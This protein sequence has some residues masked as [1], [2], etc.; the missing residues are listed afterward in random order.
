M[1]INDRDLKNLMDEVAVLKKSFSGYK[2]ISLGE[3]DVLESVNGKL[4]EFDALC[5]SNAFFDGGFTARENLDAVAFYLNGV[6]I[7]I[8]SAVSGENYFSFGGEVKNGK[9][10]LFIKTTRLP[11]IGNERISVLGYVEKKDY[12]SRISALWFDPN[13]FV[14]MKNGAKKNFTIDIVSNGVK[15]RVA[16]SLDSVCAAA[17]LDGESF[18]LVHGDGT[19]MKAVKFS[20]ETGLVVGEPINFE[21]DANLFSG[22]S[23]DDGALF[24]AQEHGKIK[25][26]LFDDSLNLTVTDTGLEGKEVFDCGENVI[27]VVCFD[28]R[29]K[30]IV[31]D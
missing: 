6:Q 15:R 22:G 19:R 14:V 4:F 29:V 10:Q 27:A 24:Y 20:A 23:S 3:E 11:A 5:D 8:M 25:K 21:A 31:Q 17:K 30:L 18:L 13:Y 28:G 1:K 26:Y 16:T 7:Y 12:E 2:N 9:N